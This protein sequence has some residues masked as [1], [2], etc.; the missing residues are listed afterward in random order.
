VKGCEIRTEIGEVLALFINEEIKERRFVEVVDRVREC[1]GLLALPHP[2]DRLRK[3]RFHGD[4][5]EAA[6]AISAVEV[7]NARV[8]FEQD[9]KKALAYAVGHGKAKIAGSDAHFL[10][11]LGNGITEA[12]GSTEEELKKAMEKAQTKASGKSTLPFV[13]GPTKLVRMYRRIFEHR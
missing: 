6:N 7:F 9:N 3:S 10:F 13:H 8:L 5:E 2:F 12:E 11:E 4:F 1:R